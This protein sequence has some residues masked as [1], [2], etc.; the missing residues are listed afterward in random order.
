LIEKWND[1]KNQCEYNLLRSIGRELDLG[2]NSTSMDEAVTYIETIRK[3]VRDRII[4]LKVAK[5]YGWD[6]VIEL[7]QL[8]E[9]ELTD[10][11]E[12]ID[13][14]HQAAT[15]MNRPETMIQTDVM[16]Q[17]NITTQDH[18]LGNE[19]Q[20]LMMKSSNAT[21]VVDM[22]TLQLDAPHQDTTDPA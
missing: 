3:K 14:A 21:T 22:G 15:I 19:N 5:R 8:N 9:E 13:R 17:R 10:Y 16:M 2:L 11:A 1:G 12:V 6:V 18:I 20:E 7:L 4:T